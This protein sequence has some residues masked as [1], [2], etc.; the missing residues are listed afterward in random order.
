M[1]IKCFMFVMVGKAPQLAMPLRTKYNE[2][3]VFTITSVTIVRR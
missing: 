2:T 3:T 1:I